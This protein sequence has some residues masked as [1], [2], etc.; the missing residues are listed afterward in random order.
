M[1]IS[2]DCEIYKA[3]KDVIKAEHESARIQLENDKELL[4]LRSIGKL[5]YQLTVSNY[6]KAKAEL[7]IAT[8][9]CGSM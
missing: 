4:E 3:Q 6:E 8:L 1:L 9:K 5:Q 7:S 2:F